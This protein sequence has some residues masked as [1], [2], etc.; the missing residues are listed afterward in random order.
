MPKD[1]EPVDFMRA[2]EVAEYL[3]L[4]VNTVKRLTDLPYYA[5]NDRGDRRYERAEVQD[6]L[7]RRRRPGNR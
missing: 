6:W 4:H 3:G 7:Q 5:I 2:T 1:Q